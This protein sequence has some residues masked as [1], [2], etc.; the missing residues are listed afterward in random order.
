[1]SGT[2][3][4]KIVIFYCRNAKSEFKNQKRKKMLLK[5]SLVF[6]VSN[7]FFSGHVDGHVALTFPPARKY[8]LDFLDTSRLE[9]VVL[10][11]D[12]VIVI[13]IVI[14]S[15]VV[16]VDSIIVVAKYYLDFL[17]NSRLQ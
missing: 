16:D 4:V 17:D 12:V 11:D 3:T 15:D 9:Q 6:V 1:M 14:V 8:D 5:I 13:I 7:F 2:T 10:V